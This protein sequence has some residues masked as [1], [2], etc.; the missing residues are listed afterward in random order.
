MR[1]LEE[2]I[3]EAGMDDDVFAELPQMLATA[4]SARSCSLLWQDNESEIPLFT[5]SR[6]Y[7]EEHLADYFSNFAQHDL[8]ITAASAP[9]RLNLGWLS[10]QAID[11]AEYASSVFFNE[12]IKPMGDDTFHALGATMCNARGSGTL[13]LH[14]G[15][16]Q[17]DFEADHCKQ[18]DSVIIHLRRMLSLRSK[19]AAANRQAGVWREGFLNTSLPTL[20]VDRT[21][22]IR[23]RNANADLLL[24]E[25]LAMTEQK[26]SL[27]IAPI[28]LRAGLGRML[29]EA[30]KSAAPQ[31]DACF[32]R[33]DRDRIWKVH[34]APLVAGTLAGCAMLTIECVDPM[35]EVAKLAPHLVAMFALTNAEAHIAIHLGNGASVEQI[36]VE[37]GSSEQTV[38]T[39]IKAIMSKM[40]ARRQSEVSAIVARLR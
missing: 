1:Y 27:W 10:S 31:A 30:T 14:R 3:Y 38:R 11:S 25:R 35:L 36:A 23:L 39:Q 7:S 24:A 9:E 40:Q 28:L 18:L 8:W 33:D 22:R 15:R 17:G 4:F 26:G 6:Y 20:V 34:V 2:S 5:H 19:L 29:H 12:W 13:G 32:A 16:G 37:R 21:L